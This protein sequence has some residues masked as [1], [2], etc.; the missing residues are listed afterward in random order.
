EAG[1]ELFGFD[2]KAGAIGNPWV[3]RFHSVLGSQFS[4]FDYEC[5]GSLL[6]SN[7]RCLSSTDFPIHFLL[8]W[9]E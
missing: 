9:R 5:D 4:V 8:R 6:I 2:Q 3:R 7:G 1:G